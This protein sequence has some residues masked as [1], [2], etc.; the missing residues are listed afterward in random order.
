MSRFHIFKIIL[1]IGAAKRKVT[2]DKSKSKNACIKFLII[3]VKYDS[4][5]TNYN[6]NFMTID[7]SKILIIFQT[8]DYTYKMF[9]KRTL[10]QLYI[11]CFT[12]YSKYV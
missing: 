7:V 9:I 5:S 4:L 2:S 1:P 6:K 11:C 3:R 8:R 12:F 10:I